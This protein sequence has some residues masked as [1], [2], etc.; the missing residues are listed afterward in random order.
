MFRYL[1]LITISITGLANAQELKLASDAWPPFTDVDDKIHYAQDIVLEALKRSGQKAAVEIID[2][3][4]VITGIS[5]LTY[6]GSAA[7]WKSAEREEL[8][9]FSKPY[10]ENRLVLVS[11]KGNPV[12]YNKLADLRGNRLAVV[13]NY[14]Y[15]AG[16]FDLK[17]L[18]ITKANSEQECLNMLLAGRVDYILLDNLFAYHLKEYQEDEVGK[19][20]AIGE[21]AMLSKPLYFAIRKDLPEAKTIIDEFNKAIVE[22]IKDGTYNELLNISWILA[23]IDEDGNPEVILGG[24]KAGTTPPDNIYGIILGSEANSSESPQ[25]YYIQGQEYKNWQ[26]VPDQYKLQPYNNSNNINILRLE[27]NKK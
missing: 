10:L 3:G 21:K 18:K 23:D 4:D 7:L 25:Q 1:F 27:L 8:L 9:S 19:Y 22:M 16:L 13:D 12:N 14:D 24:D 15:G 17:T 5:N 20:L 6:D 11:R 26:S 2:F